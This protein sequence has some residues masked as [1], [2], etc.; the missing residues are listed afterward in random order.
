M[1]RRR[2]IFYPNITLSI[3]DRVEMFIISIHSFHEMSLS[4]HDSITSYKQQQ[5]RRRTTSRQHLSV[6]NCENLW[7]QYNLSLRSQRFN[8]TLCSFVLY[9]LLSPLVASVDPAAFNQQCGFIWSDK[10]ASEMQFVMETQYIFP[11]ISI[12]HYRPTRWAR[13][14][15]SPKQIFV[16]FL[17]LMSS[18]RFPLRQLS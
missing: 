17:L 6:S 4:G 13:G 3:V 8:V 15:F 5:R 7:H 9:L 16:S 11:H 14:S 2:W 18:C 10:G 12:S 1:M